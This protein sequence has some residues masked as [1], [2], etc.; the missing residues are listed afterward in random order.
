[1]PGIDLTL[2]IGKGTP[3]PAPRLLMEALQNVEVTHSDSDRSGFQITFQVGRT[4]PS[5]RLDDGLVRNPLLT[6]FNR[7]IIVITIGGNAQV[8]MD[9]IITQQEF[10]PNPE[11]GR[12]TLTIT[13]EDVSVMMDQ[14]TSKKVAHP[15]QNES[16]IARKI[17]TSVEY[18][19]YGLKP[20]VQQ[21]P[22]HITPTRN[23]RTP[24]QSGSDLAYLQELG[25]RFD[26]VFF[27]TPG[28]G[29]G[30]N[31]AYWGPR[32]RGNRP[33][34]TITVNMGPFTNAESINLQLNAQAATRVQ[35]SVHDRRTNQIQRLN[36]QESDRPVL[37]QQ[38]VLTLQQQQGVRRTQIYE[39]TGHETALAQARTQAMVN[40]SAEDGITVSG[41]LDTIRYGK[42]L[43]LRELVTLRGVGN[44]HDGLYYVRSVTHRIRKGE[45]QQSFVITR[46]GRGSTISRAGR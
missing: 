9:G 41:D 7:V 24:A 44:T 36:V 32:P 31:Q 29:V 3:P 21:P 10:S 37:A 46:E 30:Q 20:D 26:Y 39:E 45:Y 1:M 12:S 17:I 40:R 27:I 8:L 28:P 33:Q 19:A 23:E 16:A 38:S 5:D 14:E 34:G 6:P 43:K 18:A 11:P 25:E 42:L 2:R 15:Q 35:G 4:G 22:T 13:G